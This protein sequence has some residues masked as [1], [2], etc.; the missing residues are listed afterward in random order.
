MSKRT[1]SVRIKMMAMLLVAAGL[2]LVIGLSAIHVLGRRNHETTQGELFQ[3]ISHSMAASLRKDIQH[4][5]ELLI[6]WADQSGLAEMPELDR[7]ALSSTVIEEVEAAWPQFG[8]E[9]EWLGRCLDNPAV[10][11]MRA[12]QR[13]HP[14]HVEILLTDATGCLVAASNKTSDFYQADESWWREAAILPSHEARLEGI[15]YDESARVYSVSVALPVRRDGG[16]RGVIK[17][18]VD[19]TPL[20]AELGVTLSADAFT[21]EVVLADGRILLRFN[22]PSV[23]PLHHHL[24]RAL[25]DRMA[26]D[27]QGWVIMPAASAERDLVG[28][29]SMANGGSRFAPMYV[30]V[31]E[32]YAALMQPVYRQLWLLSG[33]GLGLMALFLLAGFYIGEREVVRPVRLLRQAAQAIASRARLRDV[34]TTNGS[35]IEEPVNFQDAV[36]LISGMSRMHASD[37]IGDLSNDFLLM[38]KRVLRYHEQLEAELAVKTGE[39]EKD[40]EIAREFQEA[41]LPKS[42]PSVPQ[43]V[44]ADVMAL[45]FYHIYKPASSVSGDLVHMI[46]LSGH[47][48]GVFVADVMGHGARSA[49][50][51]AILRTLLQNA[52]RET[53][54]PGE[55]MTRMNRQFLEMLPAG[56]DLIFATALYA[57]FD[58]RAQRVRFACAGHPSPL[59]VN[60]SASTV[61]AIIDA[62]HH[63]PALGVRADAAYRGFGVDLNAGDVF[64]LY[65]DGV[66]EAPDV[67]GEEFGEE[68]LREVLMRNHDRGG[69]AIAQSVIAAL[70]EFMD[71]VV[72]PDDI[73]LVTI[74]VRARNA[75]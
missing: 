54:D 53:R 21:R 72:T 65:T 52:A 44:D 31:R 48:A 45:S 24:S 25:M 15:S 5:A 42:Y 46:Q 20:L 11:R 58:T 33:A 40:L 2:P 68:R 64:L 37:E 59:R 67:H 60:R 39:I 63:D 4:Q 75:D 8:P 30:V 1:V 18:V 6:A 23:L 12:F 36:A 28:Y 74:G 69:E 14:R 73:C 3:A 66:I 10:D 16:L 49:L 7:P 70:H 34:E 55:L 22:D 71:V 38:A 9:D 47:E 61:E 56:A 19:I 57:V 27:R 32:D 50:I 62:Q 43:P 13:L 26:R 35:A 17:S 41:L 51:S 29:S